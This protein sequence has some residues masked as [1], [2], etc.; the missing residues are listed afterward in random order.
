MFWRLKSC[1][2]NITTVTARITILLG[3]LSFL[4]AGVQVA[5]LG[6]NLLALSLDSA[7]DDFVLL[8]LLVL[9]NRRVR[10]VRL[11]CVTC[12]NILVDLLEG[13]KSEVLLVDFPFLL[14]ELPKVHLMQ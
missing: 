6:S 1:N 11:L 8:L 5:D 12:S 2:S 13:G 3:V 14:V 4:D 10:L 9:P 7:Q